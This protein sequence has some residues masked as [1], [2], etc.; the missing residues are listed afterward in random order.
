MASL[1]LVAG[2]PG[3]GKSY[4]CRWLKGKWP[5]VELL[6]PDDI[7][8]GIWDEKGY[9]D[10]AGKDRLTQESWEA[11][12]ALLEKKMQQGLSL[13]LDYPFSGKQKPTLEKLV[14]KYG[15]QP[16]TIRLVGDFE[17]LCGRQ[18][19]RDL[20]PSRHLGHIMSHYHKGDVLEDRREADS[21]VSREEF[22]H[23]C[24][25]RGYGDFALGALQEVDVTDFQTI[26]YDKLQEFLDKHL[27]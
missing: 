25:S 13:C 18:L 12:Y 15:Y 9:E 1:I 20:D 19:K 23:R 14:A 2:Y 27:V 6:S 17:V 26:P 21:L 8:E 10:Q 7:K 24:Q 16:V 5:Q 3:T 11:F 22:L 4:F